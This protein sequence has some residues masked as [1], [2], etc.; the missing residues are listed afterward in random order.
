MKKFECEPKIIQLQVIGLYDVHFYIYFCFFGYIFYISKM[1]WLLVLK[2]ADTT[3]TEDGRLEL[4]EFL[5]TNI[6]TLELMVIPL[7]TIYD[8]MV[9][10][11]RSWFS[12]SEF[13][14]I[15]LTKRI[16]EKSFNIIFQHPLLLLDKFMSILP[17]KV[18]PHNLVRLVNIKI[19]LGR[20]MKCVGDS[21]RYLFIPLF[22][23]TEK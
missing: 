6:Y 23:W 15:K 8:L 16:Y 17:I 11:L 21:E 12:I 4:A 22:S 13:F 14:I 19:L 3:T 18:S 5:A 10:I 9:Y 7:T 1:L 20:K 2:C